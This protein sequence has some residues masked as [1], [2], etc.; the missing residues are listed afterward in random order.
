[1]TESYSTL[2]KS[3]SIRNKSRRKAVKTIVGGVT[4]LAAYQVLPSVWN[5]PI[6]EQI[7]LPAHA[8]TS[9]AGLQDP[10]DIA[11]LEGTQ[12]SKSVKIGSG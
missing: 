4:A 1:M 7:F 6:I 10:C 5:K 9:A 12:D 8:A 11:L 2:G 3:E